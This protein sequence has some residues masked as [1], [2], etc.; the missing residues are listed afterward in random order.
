MSRTPADNPSTPHRPAIDPIP[1]NQ[2]NLARIDRSVAIP[3]YD[4]RA[5]T[6]GIVHIG[7]GNFHRAHQ[8]WYLHRLYQHGIT[9][10]WAI[11][12]AGVRPYDAAMREKLRRQDY[13]STLI[14]LDPSAIQ[15]EVI[16][17]IID[18]LP[19]AAD[20]GALIQRLAQPDTRIVTLTVTEGGYYLA[21]TTKRFDT[22]H[23]DIQQDARRPQRPQTVFGILVAALRLRRQHGVGP[24]TGL[25]CDNLQGNGRILRQAV[26][27]L[28]QLSDPGLADWI[29]SECAFPNAMVD[30]IV[31]ATGPRELALTR[32]FGIEDAAPVAHEQYRQWVIEDRFCRGRPD[33]DRAGA[34]F[35]DDVHRHETMKL[36]ILNGGHQIIA[37]AGQ[38]LGIA[39]IADAMAHPQIN[40]LYR[41]IATEE[42]APHVDAVPEFTPA[43]Y[44]ERIAQRFANPTLGDTTRRVAF[45]GSSRHPEFVIPSIRDGLARGAPVSGLALVSA[46]WARY[47][48]GIRDDGSNIEPND[49]HWNALTARAR[50][51]RDTPRAWLAMRRHYGDL[52]DAPRFADAFERW[53]RMLYTHRLTATLDHYLTH[54]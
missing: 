50:L 3:N 23:P 15:A 24:L 25:S 35:C 20:H 54:P 43:Q 34:T 2:A 18:Y 28:A 33:W 10:D 42:I 9:Q 47:C 27:S 19:V 41:K 22:T 48:L 53:L 46:I 37:A 51:A 1:L 45:D 13:L 6:P 7:L 21:P 29:D 4:R 30:C 11:I 44:L 12:G 39:T 14:R 32:E 16:G 17:A 31:P 38:L 26:V 8:A 52:A 40:A 5:L 36:R 49:P